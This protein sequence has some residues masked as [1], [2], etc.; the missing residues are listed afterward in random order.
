MD[1]TLTITIALDI[2]LL[3]LLGL[4]V[5][6]QLRTNRSMINVQK[7]LGE[8]EKQ[9]AESEAQLNAILNVNR[10]FVETGDEKE[11]IALMLELSLRTTNAM[12]AS[13]VPLD[14]R[15]QPL[16]TTRVGE[17]PF[18]IPDAFLEYLASSAVRHVCS[19]CSKLENHDGSCVLL[20]GPFSEAMGIFCFPLRYSNRSL[21]MLNLYMPDQKLIPAQKLAFLNSLVD[22]TALALE[23]DRLRQREITTLTQLRSTN[24]KSDLQGSLSGMLDNLFATLNVDFAFLI[25][26]PE[27]AIAQRTWLKN[28]EICLGEFAPHEKETFE[29]VIQAAQKS[30]QVQTS[31]KSDSSDESNQLAW[32]AA[33][34]MSG[35]AEPVGVL[36]VGDRKI[37]HFHQRHI[38]L[39]QGMA[40]QM[41]VLIYNAIHVAGLEYKIMMDERTRLAREIH[42]GIAQTLGFLKLQVA[43]MLTY[44]E[45]GDREKLTNALRLS[46]T[47]LSSAY[48][49]ARQA[50]DGLRITPGAQDGNPLER[51]LTQMAVEFSSNGS[52]SPL[53]VSLL[54][55]DVQSQ[56]LPEVHAQ[57]IRITQEALSNVRK[58][59]HAQHAWISCFQDQN[60]LI[61][62]IQDDGTGFAVED[63]S[64]PAQYGLRGM[65]ERSDLMSA[66]FQ[67]ISKPGH[68][69]TVRICLPLQENKQLEV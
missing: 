47:T 34:I 46:Y 63:V 5:L 28:G 68:G 54:R 3:V 1:Q 27:S 40:E 62:E 18:P 67:V 9:R 4:V 23:S 50:I 35:A 33:P 10:K 29:H 31:E 36:M 30:G 6:V 24:H 37:D 41:A 7:K 2:F 58:H 22:A 17:F 59:A 69:T 14:E 43:Q 21:G 25:L 66:D 48:Q 8:A 49:D 45:R 13:F 51:W 19:A 61:L 42:D 55:L 16:A 60:D 32:I 52:I 26:D 12:G 39:V 44:L 57:L 53:E 11:I 64:G 15:G 20:K 56:L 65:R 38:A